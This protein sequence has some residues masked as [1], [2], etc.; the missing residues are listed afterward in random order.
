[1]K[2][3]P[4]N[5]DEPDTGP[6]DLVVPVPPVKQESKDPKKKALTAEEPQPFPAHVQVVNDAQKY[7]LFRW[8]VSSL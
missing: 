3:Y 8:L 5:T 6:P 2:I 1:M 4:D 7:A